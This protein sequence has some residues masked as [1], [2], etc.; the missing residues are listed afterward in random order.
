MEGRGLIIS[1]RPVYP[2]N[3]LTFLPKD[4]T[5]LKFD[6]IHVLLK[7]DLNFDVEIIIE[8]SQR[9]RVTPT[10]RLIFIY[11][12]ISVLPGGFFIKTKKNPLEQK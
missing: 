1:K 5:A 7:S 11:Y 8:D 2:S 4:F 10:S 12:S 6:W 3:K 9:Y